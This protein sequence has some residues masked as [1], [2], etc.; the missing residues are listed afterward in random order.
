[1]TFLQ[2]YRDLE[3]KFQERVKKD[4]KCYG[5]ESY[6]LPNLTPQG[7][8]DFVLVGMEPSS[9]ASPANGGFPRNFAYSMGDYILHWSARRHLCDTGQT[10][11][12][13]D[14]AKGGMPTEQA[15][16]TWKKRWPKWYPLL[17]DELKLVAKPG[18][19]VI[20]I[21]SRVENFLNARQT[22]GYAGSILHYSSNTRVAWGIAPKL[23]PAKYREFAASVSKADIEIIVQELMQCKAFDGYRDGVL[24]KLAKAPLSDS[25]KMLMFTYK[26]LFAVLRREAGI[27]AD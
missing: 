2:E 10:Y 12:I 15:K 20:A 7:P 14:L 9:N 5:L 18:A 19:P 11:H 22:P 1:M 27:A 26:E 17:E 24:E 25:Y 21:G 3:I 16:K 23:M 4:N 13:T 8:V 6:Y